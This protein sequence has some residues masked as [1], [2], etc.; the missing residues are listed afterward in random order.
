MAQHLQAKNKSFVFG[1]GTIEQNGNQTFLRRYSKTKFGN[2]YYHFFLGRKN[3]TITINNMQE[4]FY[5]E[6]VIS[7]STSLLVIDSSK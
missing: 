2:K 1:K 6:V 7:G 5:C 3:P 4:S